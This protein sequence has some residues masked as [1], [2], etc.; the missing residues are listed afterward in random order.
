MKKRFLFLIAALLVLAALCAACSGGAPSGELPGGDP[1]GP[2]NTDPPSDPGLSNFEGVVFEGLT[3]TYDGQEHTLT[4][5][6]APNGATVAYTQNSATN[7]GTYG[8]TAVLTKEGYNQKTLTA[9]LQINKAVIDLSGLTFPGGTYAYN[10]AERAV[11]VAGTVPDTVTVTYENDKGTN[12]GTYNA[13]AT[14]A[15]KDA[16][17]YT[18]SVSSLTATLQIDRAVITTAVF[19]GAEFPFDG[20][21]HSVSVTGNP[22]GT[23]VV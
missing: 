3:V 6:G 9:T 4:V 15:P 8:A 23:A 13:T 2:Q 21:A 10:G 22:A 18:V 17:N 11:T 12:A 1:S 5:T 20:E 7:A 19:N 16:A 14:F